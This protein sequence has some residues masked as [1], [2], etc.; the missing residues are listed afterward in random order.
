M[1]KKCHFL[2]YLMFNDILAT[3]Q[4]NYHLRKDPINLSLML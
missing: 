3:L 4:W 2:K 1:F